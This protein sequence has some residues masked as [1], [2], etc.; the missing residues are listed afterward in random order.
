M[1]ISGGSSVGGEVYW[2]HVLS[3]HFTPEARG[4]AL[5]FRDRNSVLVFKMAG[6]N[7]VFVAKAF[8]L[9]LTTEWKDL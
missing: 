2:P 6:R 4:R 7:R 9:L 5:Y 8:I 1:S 3:K